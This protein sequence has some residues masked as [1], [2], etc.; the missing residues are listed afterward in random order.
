[1]RRESGGK[2]AANTGRLS[3]ALALSGSGSTRQSGTGTLSALLALS[4]TGAV[5]VPGTGALSM[6]LTL[7]GT[8]SVVTTTVKPARPVIVLV[9]RRKR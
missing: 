9:R 8:G 6:S 2:S 5:N 4:G 1:V 3:M 7:S